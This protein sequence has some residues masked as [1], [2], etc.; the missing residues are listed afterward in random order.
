MWT[1]EMLVKIRNL[2]VIMLPSDETK[3]TLLKGVLE[4]IV[5]IGFVKKSWD[6]KNGFAVAYSQRQGSAHVGVCVCVCVC[7]RVSFERLSVRI[8]SAFHPPGV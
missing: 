3:H 5:L 6:T 8:L 2:R 1:P 7:E 4:V